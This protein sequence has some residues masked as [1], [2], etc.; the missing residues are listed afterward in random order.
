MRKLFVAAAIAV[1]VFSSGAVAAQI[2]GNYIEARTANVWV[3]ACFANSEM[4]QI[5]KEAV[6]GWQVTGGEW[7]GVPLAGLSVAA[8]VRSQETLGVSTNNP[9]SAIVIVDDRATPEQAKALV[10]FARS[11]APDLLSRVVRVDRSRIEFNL[12]QDAGSGHHHGEAAP[13]AAK[14]VVGD[15][16]RI[17]TRAID[18]HDSTCA[19]AELYYQPLV[20]S[21]DVQPAFATTNQFSGN[22]LGTRWSSPGHASAFVGTFSR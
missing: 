5:G 7:N 4:N 9:S 21:A 22:G 19:N 17:E 6:L 13:T 16:A 12:A 2:S 1:V 11:G 3:G 20:A 14:F 10:A 15:V 18:H 8:I